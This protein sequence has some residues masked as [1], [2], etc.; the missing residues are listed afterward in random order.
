MDMK[1]LKKLDDIKK[2]PIS[3]K[4]IGIESQKT[5]QTS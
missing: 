4:V 2:F 1:K 3:K 5:M